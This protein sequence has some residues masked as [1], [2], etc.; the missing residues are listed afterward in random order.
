LK[1]K[2]APRHV[3]SEQ[4][5]ASTLVVEAQEVVQRQGKARDG[6]FEIKRVMR[7]VPVVVVEEERETS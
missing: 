5:H 6:R 2:V 3:C 1:I 7:A 4:F